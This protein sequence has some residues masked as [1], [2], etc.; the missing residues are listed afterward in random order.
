MTGYLL[1][2][3][4]DLMMLGGSMFLLVSTCHVDRALLLD[5]SHYRGEWRMTQ[6]LPDFQQ[7][8][9]QLTYLRYNDPLWVRPV[10]SPSHQMH[11]P[12]PRSCLVT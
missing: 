10:R 9:P 8:P 6:Q 11:C 5:S 1:G 12:H 4:R 3:S 2:R 7:G